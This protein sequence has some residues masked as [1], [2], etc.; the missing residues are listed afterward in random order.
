MQELGRYFDSSG[1]VTAGPQVHALTGLPPS[2]DPTNAVVPVWIGVSEMALAVALVVPRNLLG[3]PVTVITP[4]AST[5]TLE[6]YC[7]VW[8]GQ[9]AGKTVL[10]S[11]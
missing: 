10:T 7:D 2:V 5:A 3:L 9:A 8:L 4:L 11:A 1:F 6:T